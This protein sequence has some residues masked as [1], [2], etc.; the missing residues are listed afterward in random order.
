MRARNSFNSTVVIIGATGIDNVSKPLQLMQA[1]ASNPVQWQRFVGG[2]ASNVA[3]GI[4][5]H[6]DALLISVIGADPV[7]QALVSKLRDTGVNVAPINTP[8]NTT[9]S[10]TAVLDEHGELFV[11][12]SDFEL[13]EQ[14]TWNEIVVRLPES[15]HKAHPDKA[16]RAVVLDANLSAQCICD[17]VSGLSEAKTTIFGLTVSPAKAAR[18]LPVANRVNVLFCNRAEASALTSLNKDLSLDQLADG[19]EKVGFNQFVISD[20]GSPALV[21]ERN[22]HE[23][24][25]MQR[26]WIAVAKRTNANRIKSTVNGAGDG[27]AAATIAH[28]IQQPNRSLANSLAV[29]GMP[30][31]AAIVAGERRPL[32]VS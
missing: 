31:A 8:N 5:E 18:W 21:Q 27:M 13:I 30:A 12:L 14:L 1:G 22:T 20:G 25:S 11:G 9:G 16:M 29:A 10:Y 15:L 23:Q 2:V 24:K 28:Y 17:A 6:L 3:R 4:S 32:P 19:L 26:H 7:G